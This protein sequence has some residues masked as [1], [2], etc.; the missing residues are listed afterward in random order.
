M[1]IH[2]VQGE[3]E[4]AKD[5]RTLARFDLVGIPAA[6][7]GVPQIEVSFD[8]DANGIVHVS[9]KDLGTGKEQKIQVK[10]SSGLRQE[11]IDRMIKDAEDHATEDEH[12]RAGVKIRND[13][14]VL[15]YS[16]EQTIRDHGGSVSEADRE[17]I[18]ESL[19]TLKAL[20]AGQDADLDEVKRASER[21]SI[22]VYKIA[23][24][25]Y[26]TSAGRDSGSGG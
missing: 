4:M 16:S 12:R 13:A 7:R 18:E 26:N 22:A 11:E 2:V 19:R 21:L 9:A 24:S 17:M 15:I 10:V 14:E 6:P 3:R 8:I 20:V 23:E 1:S 25:M 5:N